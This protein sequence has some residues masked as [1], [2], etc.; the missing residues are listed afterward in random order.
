MR[1]TFFCVAILAAACGDG[2]ATGDGGTPASD[3]G[4]TAEQT[5]DHLCEEV[6]R[7]G[8][9]ANRRCCADPAGVPATL[10][11]CIALVQPT[12]IASADSDA[13]RAGRVHFDAS[14]VEEY[15]AA[16]RAD[17]SDCVAISPYRLIDLWEGTLGEGGD[18]SVTEDDFSNAQSCANGLGCAIDYA[19]YAG[20]CRPL[21]LLGSPCGGA[22]PPCGPGLYC[23]F[24]G[25]TLA[26]AI[27][28][29]DGDSCTSH[30]QCWSYYCDATCRPAPGD[31]DY[32]L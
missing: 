32:C 1:G 27:L 10:E 28:R 24:E 15:L 8:C 11:A 29:D 5:I 19:T 6:A 17:A 12:C 2:R 4:S 20:T 21:G 22:E 3:G 16:Y 25:S 13:Y 14:R 26:C 18:C 31:D 30:D 9:E 7:I 23:D